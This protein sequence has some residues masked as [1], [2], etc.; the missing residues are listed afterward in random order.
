[1]ENTH[2]TQRFAVGTIPDIPLGLI[3]PFRNQPRKHFDQKG[4]EELAASIKE[5][6]QITPAWVMPIFD[7]PVIEYELIAGERRW[8]ACGIAGIAT[9]RGEIRAP[10]TAAKQYLDS[11]MENFGRRDC[12]HL[13][14]ARAIEE[15]RRI[16]FGEKPEWGEKVTEK[17][18]KIFVHSTAWIN[19]YRSLLRLHPEVQAMMEPG[20]EEKQRLPFQVAI[21]LANLEQESQLTIARHIVGEGLRLKPALAHIRAEVSDDIRIKKNGRRGRPHRDY[22]VLRTFLKSLGEGAEGL[23]NMSHKTFEEMFRHRPVRE[24]Q[25]VIEVLKKG[26]VS[27]K[28]LSRHCAVYRFLMK[29]NGPS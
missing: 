3:R 15:M 14:T 26:R 20:V 27:S 28:I 10:E 18:A 22:D 1:M 4:L 12:T 25:N 8:R 29:V 23:L 6:G 7:D 19:Q 16:H 17:L 21:A 2:S 5:E 13:E 24:L 11:V 9:L